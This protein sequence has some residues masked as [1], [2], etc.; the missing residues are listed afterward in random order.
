MHYREIKS[1][2]G[3]DR[4]VKLVFVEPNGK[5]WTIK[6]HVFLGMDG[7]PYLVAR[8]WIH[9][10]HPDKRWVTL[11]KDDGRSRSFKPLP[12]DQAAMYGVEPPVDGD[13]EDK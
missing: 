2:D 10:W 9:W 5:E 8:G 3:P 6:G 7:R 12:S 4:L 13:K 11:Q 1:P